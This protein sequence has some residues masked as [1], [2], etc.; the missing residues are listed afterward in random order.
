MAATLSGGIFANEDYELSTRVIIE[1]DEFVNLTGRP[2]QAVANFIIDGGEMFLEAGNAS[3]EF[4]LFVESEN[5]GNVP[6]ITDPNN[7]P[8]ILSGPQFF[9]GGLFEAAASGDTTFTPRGSD[10]NATQLSRTNVEIPLSF[11]SLDLGVL[12]PGDRLA[13]AYDFTY[14]LTMTGPGSFSE[15]MFA[16]FSDPLMLAGRPVLEVTFTPTSQVIPE[17]S[18]VIVWSLLGFFGLAIHCRHPR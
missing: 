13:L 6:I 9:A 17:P 14:T 11:Q 7:F 15:I 2:A 8:I 5:L 16:E 3:I 18:T 12:G 1:S 4:E 10:I